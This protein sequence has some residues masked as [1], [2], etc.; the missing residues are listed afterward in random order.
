MEA[1]TGA[2]R[3]PVPSFEPDKE[4]IK[5]K[6]I[7]KG[8]FPT[9]K[10][11]HTLRKKEIQKSIRKAKRMADK[12]PEKPLPESQKRAL[13][14]EAH[15]Q[16]L[17]REYR[18]FTK[19][20]KA[21]SG[22]RNGLL[23]VGNPWEGL[24]RVRL[25]E[26]ASVSKEYTGEKLRG[27]NLQ[28][29]SEI[30]AKRNHDDFQCLLDDDIE[31]GS[32]FIEQ[33]IRSPTKSRGGDADTIR[34]LINR[35]SASDLSMHDWKFSRLMNQ[36]GLQFTERNLLR[37][38]EGLGAIGNWKHA[39]S[40][41]EWVYNSKEHR[42]HKSRFVYTKLLAV[43]GK[44]RRPS[45][46]LRIFN[47]M[48]ED[49]HIY[50]DMPAYHSIAVTLGQ[51]GLLKELLNIIE[52]MR[53]KPS[54]RTKNMRNK[55]WDPRLEP[56]IVVFNAV[57]NACVPSHQ[58]KGVYWVLEQMRRSGLKPNGATYGLAMEV[59][60]ESGKYDLVHE[61]F[62]KMRRSGET[63]KALT[64]RVLVRAFW[65][66]D[67]V[68][69]ALV[70]VSDMEQ[71]G[72][73]GTASVYYELACC[74]CNK[75][76]WQEAMVMV[77]K[78]KKLSLTK[79]LEVA[80]T[81]MILSCMD[82]GHVE[83]CISI[84]EHM[85]EH[86]APNIG[87]INA[88]L[89]VYGHS[90]MFSK[91]KELF[92]EAKG[93]K[94]LFTT[95][96]DN[97]GAFLT[98]DVHTYSSILEAS[99]SAHQWE[100][101]EYVYKEMAFSGYQLNQD[102]HG[103]LLVEASRAGKWHLLEHAF[104]RIL[105]SGE[106][107]HLSFF[108]EMVCQATAQHN[109]E[110]VATIVNTMAHASFQVSEK[111]WT[112]LFNTNRERISRVQLQK[113]LETIQN[114]DMMAEATISNLKRSLNTFCGSRLPNMS[115]YFLETISTRDPTSDKTPSDDIDGKLDGNKSWK[116]LK[117][118]VDMVDSHPDPNKDFPDIVNGDKSGFS[119]HHITSDIEDD[120]GVALVPDLLGYVVNEDIGTGLYNRVDDPTDNAS[121]NK[122]GW[123]GNKNS[124]SISRCSSEDDCTEAA[125]DM[126]INQKKIDYPHE[127]NLPSASEI[128][129]VWRVSRRRDGIL[130]PFQLN[131]K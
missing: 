103:W 114:S 17:A 115:E 76:R 61:F 91:A 3:V 28:E 12:T 57:L 38:V 43:L 40:V 11:V 112:D 42:H 121:L 22:G 47:L 84:F 36:S 68:N 26:L 122:P 63:P 79:P 52:S 34:F 90:D 10:I 81:G 116:M 130:F 49:S 20:L 56:D 92:E 39:L 98:P 30:L 58:W 45:E 87:T 109:Y 113:L 23:M 71:R 54:K 60:L 105:E 59:M 29:L 6:L 2:P 55:N 1:S 108:T 8:V 86:C 27:E 128:L 67:K 110:K 48:H 72:V 119:V 65:K 80:F 35:L 41:V 24:E 88:M 96:P 5:R 53:L 129:E 126:L 64:Y 124:I 104:E 118:S 46:A 94:S 83:D 99:A 100:Y 78:M 89:K 7:Q 32:C 102:K 77:D 50:P 73:V 31:E 123:F 93:T 85:K 66:E 82:G 21:K 14:E 51:A 4:K 9:S 95:Y 25:R 16:T 111:Q 37:I 107:P 106:V 15:F 101:F 117:P 74:L 120:G 44:A 70:A 127:S 75:G 62:G 19:N 69:E 18:A 125:L 97:G 33:E 131:C 13:V